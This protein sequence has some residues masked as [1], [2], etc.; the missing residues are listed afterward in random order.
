MATRFNRR[1]VL[2]LISAALVAVTLVAY[3]PVRHNG[4]VSYDDGA[5]ITK[6]PN[7]TGG[8]IRD[9]VIWAFTKSH[10][11]NWH[12]LAWLSHMLDCHFWGLEPSWHHF[13]SLLLHVV[14]SLLVFWVLMKM[15]GATWASAFVAAAFALHPL[16][17]ESVA[18][19]A[20][21]KTVLSGLFWFFTIAAYIWYA[22]HPRV[23]RYLLLLGVYALSIMTKPVVV[24][25]PLVLFLL[26]Y[27]PLGRLKFGLRIE[28][29]KP[30][31]ADKQIIPLR[32]LVLEKIPLLGLSVILSVIT[33]VV[34]R[35]SGAVV[36][37]EKVTFDIRVA[38][39][40]ISYI[41]YI[42]KMIWPNRLAVFYP[43]LRANL[44][45]GTAAVCTLIFIL[46]S[47]FSIYLGRRR[48]HIATGWL[49][50]AGTLV[51]MTGLVQVGMQSM[52]DRY[53]YIPM[54]GLLFIA[55]WTVRDF[56]ISRPRWKP[57]AVI[58]G[59]AALLLMVAL[60]RTQVKYWRNSE[61]LFGHALRVTENNDVAEKGY[62]GAMLGAGRLDEAEVHL[63]NALRIHP[64]YFR[65]GSD[66]GKVYLKQ[67]KLNEAEMCFKELLKRKK[68]SAELYYNLGLALIMQNKCDEAIECFTSALE[69]DPKYPDAH[70][71]MGTALLATG[72]PAAAVKCLNEA[73]RTTP[74]EP[75]VYEKLGKAYA[76]LG[77]YEQAIRN[78]MKADELRPNNAET[79]NNLAWLL[80][81]AGDIS[82][83]KTGKAIEFAQRACEL[84]DNKE[85]AVLDTLAAAYAA[86]GRFDE[87]IT[88]AS[89]AVKAAEAAGQE[90]LAGGIQ[91]RIKL[92]QAGQRYQ[93]K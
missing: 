48:K 63:R 11:G 33:F 7:V 39:M 93:Q 74:D 38:N 52:A 87:A 58:L 13:V 17:V 83:E 61:T 77:E 1:Q 21:R 73:L 67:G 30:K 19:A 66:L 86:A 14:N 69:L 56:V 57:A 29:Q 12:P 84:T 81:T 44:S 68:D 64:G 55:V 28:H 35:H 72:K 2:F 47:I 80:A 25:L 88:T 26:D 15:T 70:N 24:T 23:G 43:H 32:R 91:N 34:Q 18:W 75:A 46:L 89:R 20:E 49:W 78:W 71:R 42:G 16:Q 85:P 27:W 8:I 4:F 82:V 6:N 54:L 65:A 41:R 51:P 62:G 50:Y 60:T 22:R 90:D 76:Q 10:S 40:F 3:E 53:M 59:I 9:S 37:L 5:Y 31:A 45:Y 92:Y 79:L 36:G